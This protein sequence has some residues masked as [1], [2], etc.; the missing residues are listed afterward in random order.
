MVE[1]TGDTT[2]WTNWNIIIKSQKAEV[3]ATYEG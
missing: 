2:D 3:A 1:S